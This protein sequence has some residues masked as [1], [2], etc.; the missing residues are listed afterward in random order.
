M[1]H[2][3]NEIQSMGARWTLLLNFIVHLVMSPLSPYPALLALIVALAVASL[4][5]NRTGAPP[6]SGRFVSL[7]GLRGYLAFFV[8]V[9]HST[10]WYF[11]L[12]TGEMTVPPS[13][14]YAHFGQD[15]VLLFF[16]ITG[17]LFWSKLIDAKRYPIDW[18][19]LYISRGMRLIPLYLFAFSLMIAMVAVLS[20]FSLRESPPALLKHSLAW[21]TFSVFGQPDINQSMTSR[22]MLGDNWT[23]PYEWFFY[24]SLPAFGL[25][26]RFVPSIWY[27]ALSTVTVV[28]FALWI[29]NTHMLYGFGGGIVAAFAAR[30]ETF[31]LWA[32]GTTAA[33]IALAAVVAGVWFFPSGYSRVVLLLLTLAF[34]IIA[35]GNS[36][37]GILTSA[38]SRTLGEMGYSI[39]L[40]HGALLFI[41]FRVI[42]GY[43]RAAALSSTEHWLIVFAVAAV[44]ILV[45]SATYRLIEAP[46]MHSTPRV[47]AWVKAKLQAAAKYRAG[48]A[49]ALRKH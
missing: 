23:L 19:K 5:V 48:S 14:L 41:T 45:C 27:L 35:C 46:A 15:S 11:F 29:S 40:L 30:S 39:Y 32:S 3:V 12:R 2:G 24:F 38:I 18:T 33:V 47:H 25:L 49:L 31:R 36:L 43:A 28:L 6:T 7:D 9:F 16:M 4:L 20:H 42:L 22:Q 17:F 21:L 1:S 37:F 10:M 26:F 34:T 13:H 8:F 44:L